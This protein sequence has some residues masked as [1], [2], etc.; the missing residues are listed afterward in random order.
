MAEPR[1]SPITWTQGHD[2]K[3]DACV[4]FAL[5]DWKTQPPK[6]IQLRAVQ[7]WFR[8]NIGR[9]RL[10]TIVPAQ[11]AALAMDMRGW[12]DAAEL[13]IVGRLGPDTPSQEEREKIQARMSELSYDHTLELAKLQGTSAWDQLVRNRVAAGMSAVNLMA[14][15]SAA[16]AGLDALLSSMITGTWTALEAM[17]ADLWETSVNLRPT[18]LASLSGNPK[19][20]FGKD[21]NVGV[22]ETKT[23]ESDD[24]KSVR[25]D[26][27]MEYSFDIQR[28]MGTI[29]KRKFDFGRLSG[30]RKAYGSAF[31][32]NTTRIDQVLK[33]PALEALSI[34]RNLLVHKANAIDPEYLRR[35]KSLDVP[36]GEI[37]HR[38][39]LDGETVVKLI[40]PA[41]N[42][43]ADLIS[44]VDEWLEQH[45]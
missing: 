2:F 37:G 8:F 36:R 42:C 27:L 44:A 5:K 16:E 14:S 1:I 32:R 3:L 17:M 10:L 19:K 20:R 40:E 29:L 4:T 22:S 21:N 25:L 12:H 18:E 35:A 45:K 43:G 9:V 7:G 11:A 34:V 24:A 28:V 38:I 15:A 39:V 6:T 26:I 13:E 33:S 41:M 23:S 30:I 31:A